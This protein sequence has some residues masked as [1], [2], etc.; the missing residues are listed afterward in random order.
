MKDAAKEGS[1]VAAEVSK[2]AAA[3]KAAVEKK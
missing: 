3:A 2:D 1:K